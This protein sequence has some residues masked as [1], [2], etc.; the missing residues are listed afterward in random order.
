MKAICD[1]ES[2]A[3]QTVS[4]LFELYYL[5]FW[6]NYLENE[7]TQNLTLAIIYFCK[8]IST[9]YNNYQENQIATL[10]FIN[11]DLPFAKSIVKIYIEI[12]KQK[13]NYLSKN[14]DYK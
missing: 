3:I 14:F 13:Q 4:Q 9:F 5:I 7:N 6:K 2:Y 10:L 11:T 8:M 1:N 12:L